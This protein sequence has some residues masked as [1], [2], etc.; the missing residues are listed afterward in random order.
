VGFGVSHALP[1][2]VALIAATDQNLVFIEEPEAHLHPNA[3]LEMASVLAEAAKR[4]V[5]V[6]VE[7]HS[8]I[9]LRGV[10]TLV[11][12]GKL[13]PDLV[14]LYWFTRN[15]QGF[16]KIHPAELDENGAFGDKWPEDFD[17]IELGAE[18]ALLDAVEARHARR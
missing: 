11:A 6:V 13:S 14:K 7:T 15:K 12:R 10:Q 2:L 17:D 1:V 16:T 8:S 5:R 3:Q 18:S 4:G 9:L